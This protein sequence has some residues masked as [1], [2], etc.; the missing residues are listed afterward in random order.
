MDFLTLFVLSTHV[1]F[2]T[3]KLNVNSLL[4]GHPAESTA[5]KRFI[6]VMHS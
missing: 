6:V 1:A 4:G 3:L 2:I 5:S